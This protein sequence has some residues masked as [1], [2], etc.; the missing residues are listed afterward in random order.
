[1][2]NMVTRPICGYIPT[3]ENEFGAPK[4][5]LPD[6]QDVNERIAWRREE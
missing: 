1:M 5:R 3:P 2:D 4:S 6:D